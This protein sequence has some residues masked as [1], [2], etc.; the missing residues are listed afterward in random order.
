[1]RTRIEERKNEKERF[2][3]LAKQLLAPHN[4]LER[5]KLNRELA[6]LV[7]GK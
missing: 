4:H 7:F 6:R 3:A 2:F 5:E 1:M